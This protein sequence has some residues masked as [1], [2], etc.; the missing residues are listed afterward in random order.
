MGRALPPAKQQVSLAAPSHVSLRLRLGAP[1]GLSVP[2][3]VTLGAMLLAAATSMIASPLLGL[4]ALGL[5]V[6]A[7][8]LLHVILQRMRT[9]GWVVAG[10]RGIARL[11]RSGKETALARWSE[12]FGVAVLAN[13]TR[14][15]CLLAFT[16]PRHTR[17]LQVRTTAKSGQREDPNASRAVLALASTV[18][19]ADVMRETGAALSPSDAAELLRTVR[20]HAMPA[21][22]RIYLSG[23]GGES[24]VLEG[25]ELRCGDRVFDLRA[26]LE[27]RGFLFHESMGSIAT[28]YQATWIRQGGDEIVLVAPL[29]PE[30]SVGRRRDV[31]LQPALLRDLKLMQST[32]GEPPPRE[33]RLAVERVFMLPLRQAL[34]RAPR[35]SRPT[36]PAR[37]SSPHA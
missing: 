6:V 10:S 2:L 33:L 17:F 23:A 16:T 5:V 1:F 15:S 12:P 20:E 37:L 14:T 25:R 8:I 9:R 3:P 18:A 30:I 34:D 28:V 4:A 32:P 29:P 22:G 31:S 19:D 26:P 11:D 21:M 27:W 13:H 35:A 7:V 36:N 24:I